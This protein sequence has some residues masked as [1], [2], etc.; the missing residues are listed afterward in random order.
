MTVN[1]TFVRVH[2]CSCLLNFVCHA[3]KSSILIKQTSLTGFDHAK[4]LKPVHGWHL[5]RSWN[6]NR[7]R[8]ANA[9]ESTFFT[10]AISPWLLLTSELVFHSLLENVLSRQLWRVF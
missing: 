4:S 7:V 9:L 2:V 10:S 1:S 6:Q 5:R 3:I 8:T